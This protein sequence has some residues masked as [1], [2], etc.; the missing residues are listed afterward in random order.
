MN[1]VKVMVV[2]TT[3]SGKTTI[4]HRIA[5]T[6]QAYGIDVNVVDVIDDSFVEDYVQEGDRTRF[7]WALSDRLT[8]LANNV[9]VTVETKTARK[10]N[11]S[12]SGE[13]NE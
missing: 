4:A 8:N 10:E 2:G 11:S 1:K 7:D 9:E 13:T 6:L 3:G 12:S 5:R